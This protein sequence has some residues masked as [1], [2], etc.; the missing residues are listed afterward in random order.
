MQKD[1]G[2]T[3]SY[4]IRT[5]ITLIKGNLELLK[6]EHSGLSFQIFQ[7]VLIQVE[8]YIDKLKIFLYDGR[9]KDVVSNE[10]D[11]ILDWDNVRYKGK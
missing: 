9:E 5:P 1:G 8:K 3:S 7:T 4:V 10:G 11:F 2:T 6:E